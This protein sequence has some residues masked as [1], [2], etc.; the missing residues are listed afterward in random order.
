MFV[1]EVLIF[2]FRQSGNH[3]FLEKHN[4]TLFTTSGQLQCVSEDLGAVVQQAQN[5]AKTS[6]HMHDNNGIVN[7]EVV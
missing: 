7:L 3:G 4:A 5:Q 1:I 2:L 6:K